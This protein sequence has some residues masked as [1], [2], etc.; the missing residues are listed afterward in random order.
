MF[1]VAPDSLN[2]M[3][4]LISRV[5]VQMREDEF[6]SS[7]FTFFFLDIVFLSNLDV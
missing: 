7:I 4:K 2:P 3:N 6:N 1:E 5:T